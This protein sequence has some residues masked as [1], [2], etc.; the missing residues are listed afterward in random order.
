MEFAPHVAIIP[1]LVISFTILGFNL[2]GDGLRDIF[3]PRQYEI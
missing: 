1:G 3:D 2:I